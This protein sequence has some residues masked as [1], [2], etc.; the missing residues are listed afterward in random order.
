MVWLVAMPCL[1]YRLP[2]AG[3]QSQ[4]MKQLATFPGAPGLVL[5]HWKVEPGAVWVVAGP[6]VLDVVFV[7]WWVGPVPDM[8]FCWI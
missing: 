2:A 4:V 8:P 7:C 5:A 3:G 1:V 6:G